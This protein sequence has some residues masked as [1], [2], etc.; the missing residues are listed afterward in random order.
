M[1]PMLFAHPFASYCQKALIAFYENA[2][3]FTFR[4]LDK[5]DPATFAEL[6]PL[7]RFPLLVDQWRSIA[8]ATIIFEHLAIYHP[9]P[10][11]L[12]PEERAAALEARFVD[13]FF[14]N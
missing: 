9:R 4:L 13:R 6:W 8:E 12:M 2:T 1:P 7:K 11:Q 5:A 3:P 10:V 14:D